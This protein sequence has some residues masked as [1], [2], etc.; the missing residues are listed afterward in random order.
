[1]NDSLA[2]TLV[3]VSLVACVGLLISHVS[4]RLEVAELTGRL[5]AAMR[6]TISDHPPIQLPT[7]APAVPIPT[8]KNDTPAPVENNAAWTCSG[9]LDP[10]LVSMRIGQEAKPVLECIQSAR[11]RNPEL[12]GRLQILVRVDA[13]GK[14]AEVNIDGM[15]DPELVR[16]A[17][18]AALKW[19]FAPPRGGECAIVSAPFRV[20][21]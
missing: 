10:A 17:G 13:S 8:A 12:T 7:A 14:A 5:D 6:V 21:R 19:S 18:N 16:C 2:R 9:T 20:G 1:M 4:L 11:A 3:A 15:K